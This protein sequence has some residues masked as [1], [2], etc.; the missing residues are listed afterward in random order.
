MKKY[1]TRDLH[2]ATAIQ[3]ASG[4]APIELEEVDGVVWF[5]FEGETEPEEIARLHWV[6]QLVIPTIKYSEALSSIKKRLFRRR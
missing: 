4:F 3:A 5:V 6:G 1:K 2:E